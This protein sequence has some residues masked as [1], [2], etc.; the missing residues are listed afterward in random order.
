MMGLRRI[1][2]LLLMLTFL[3]VL[4]CFMIH[5]RV[6]YTSSLLMT[7]KED[8]DMMNMYVTF[9]ANYTNKRLDMASENHPRSHLKR[10]VHEVDCQQIID[11]EEEYISVAN[12]TMSER[13]YTFP[14]DKEIG[15]L[16]Q[17]CENFLEVYNYKYFFV[18][19]EELGFPIAYTI[20]TYKDAVQ[21]EKL[22]R[23]IY[24][25]HNLYCIHVDQSS[26]NTLLYAM[27][28]IAKCLPNVLIAS[29]L[30]DVIYAGF[31]R[32]QADVNCMSDLLNKTDVKWRYVINL[33]SQA[34]PLKTNSEIIKILTIYNGTNSIES[35][36][37]HNAIYRFNET[38]VV[39]NGRLKSTG[40]KKDPPPY[41]ITV[42]KG[43]AYGVF[44]RDFVN[45][46]LN[47]LKAQGILKWLEDTYS[48]DETFWATLVFNK[49]LNVPGVNYTGVPNRKLWIAVSTTWQGPAEVCHGKYVHD[50]CVFGMGDL[51]KLVSEKELFANKFYHD[52]QPLALQCME[53]W[54]YNKTINTIPLQTYYYRNLIKS[55]L[56]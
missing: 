17:N 16:A 53:E 5:H 31:S 50:I 18:S 15:D 2:K 36:Y 52:Y 27:K 1:R 30:E 28:S 33:P 42:G 41:N 49:H 47:D 9:S 19:P 13:N 44:S 48:P 32:L 22:L 46:S 11:G 39:K 38:Y 51:N 35:V 34:Y 26:D 3:V 29:K 14:T 43:S 23:A 7:P 45:Y 10:F 54:M 20:L 12:R 24:R 37:D 4:T 55:V 56:H 25:P 8:I 40:K 6:F 21:T